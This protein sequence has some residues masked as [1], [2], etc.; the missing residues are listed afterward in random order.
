MAK[1]DAQ[2]REMILKGDLMKTILIICLP[3]ALYQ[4]FNSTYNLIDQVICANISTDAQNAVASIGQIKST[5]A[6]IGA[7]LA[8]GGGVLVARLY[9]AGEVK[10]ARY[11]SS[12]LFFMAIVVS[13]L[14]MLLFIPFAE[15]LLRLCQVAEESIRIG[16][17]YFRLQMLELIFVTINSVF[18]G[19]EKAKGNSKI[20]LK[21]NILVL[22]IKLAL[23]SS[24]VLWFG[25]KNIIFVEV[26]TIIGQAVLTCIGLWYLFNLNNLIRISFS[27]LLPKKEYV[28]P[29]LKLSIPIFLGKFVMSLG[30]VV[31]NGLCG[32]YWN[33]ATDGLI[34]G[35]LGVS[36]NMC[37]LIT[38]PT[39]SFE[40]GESSVVSQ[41]L[42]NRNIKRAVRAFSK[43]LIMTAVICLTGFVLLRF[44]LLD[45]IVDLFTSADG[46]S[47]A[48][49][50]MVKEIFVWDSFTIIALGLNAAVL[51]LLYGFGQT[52][53]SSVLNFSRIG[54]RILIL[55]C[56]HS[57]FPD[58]SP[59]FCA[60]L[61][62]GI[63]NTVILVLSLLF[64]LVF[65]IKIKR[66]GYKGM[67][68]S[69]PEPEM[70]ELKYD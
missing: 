27:M 45:Q 56:L 40:E 55:I 39:N 38:S 29:I 19:L 26:A 1:I 5:I 22:L 30:K 7:G 31:V 64:L 65:M 70:S 67:Y 37:G 20:V 8:A 9:G 10:K 6:A 3:L 41:N 18:I 52:G 42:G 44:I 69:D 12:N 36:N 4:F 50:E 23:T 34:V 16:V 13:I 35:A 57:F 17:G 61:S 51:G 48:F 21:L 47:E 58:L 59:T 14:V 24:F 43:T 15:P 68:L 54:I 46:K 66:K 11:A 63:S 49:K 60:G 33:Q 2:R 25:W 32:N 28:L 62:M 53:L